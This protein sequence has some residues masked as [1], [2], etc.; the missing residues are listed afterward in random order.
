[1]TKRILTVKCPSCSTT[2]QVKTRSVEKV[3]QCPKCQTSVIVSATADTNP[4]AEALPEAGLW[5]NPPEALPFAELLPMAQ[6]APAAPPATGRPGRAA[7]AIGIIAAVVLLGVG[8]FFAIR[9]GNGG[10]PDKPEVVHQDKPKIPHDSGPEKGKGSGEITPVEGGEAGKGQGKGA[11]V[12]QPIQPPQ[13]DSAAAAKA[14]L[15]KAASRIQSL[16]RQKRDWLL[17][18]AGGQFASGKKLHVRPNE[19]LLDQAKQQFEI[20]QREYERSK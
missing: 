18:S 1:M 19:R 20:A 15:D 12:Q 14:N 13:Q 3:V 11:F 9:G 6:P 8:I 4:D 2:L 10:L 16:E 5:E 17:A 7:I